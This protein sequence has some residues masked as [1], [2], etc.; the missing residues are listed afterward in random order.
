MNAVEQLSS[1]KLT[2]QQL[3]V[4]LEALRRRS[5]LT[6]HEEQRARIIKKQKLRAKDR[7]RVLMAEVRQGG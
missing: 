7:I 4:E 2:H 5:H 3:E 6:P 1:L